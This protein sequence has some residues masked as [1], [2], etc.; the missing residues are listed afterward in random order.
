MIEVLGEQNGGR[1]EVKELR[2]E[3]EFNRKLEKEKS[4]ASAV[5]M[6][7]VVKRWRWVEAKENSMESHVKSLDVDSSEV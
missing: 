5:K 7:E 6:E 1:K 3:R 4:Q 2:K